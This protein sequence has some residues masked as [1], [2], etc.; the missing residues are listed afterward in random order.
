MELT[1]EQVKSYNEKGYVFLESA[2]PDNI[3]SRLNEEFS[4]VSAEDSPRRVLENDKRTVRSI[5]APHLTNKTF[6]QLKS[7]ARLLEPVMQ[8]LGSGVY[9]HQY[10][11]NVKAGL[12]GEMW[13]WHQDYVYWEQEDGIATPQLINASIYMDEVTEFN[14]PL[15]II[16]GSHKY[17][18]IDTVINDDHSES[19]ASWRNHLSVDLKYTLDTPLLR[20]LVNAYGIEAPKGPAGSVLIFDPLVAHASA[21]NISPFDRKLLIMTY[22]S[23]DNLPRRPLTRPDFLAGRDFNAIKVLEDK[24]WQEELSIEGSTVV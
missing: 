8:L 13:N 5:Y 15:A 23:V 1:T 17:E 18:N 4:I 21:P 16:P 20:K 12:A 6:D 3:V 11:I 2:I 9:L 10:K 22:N 7:Y 19:G 24:A 14:G